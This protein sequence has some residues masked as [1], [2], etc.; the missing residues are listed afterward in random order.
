MTFEELYK[1]IESRRES[2]PDHSNTAK[3]LHAGKHQIS[4]KL[5]EEAA[6]S[7]MAAQF[8]SKNETAT[9]IAQLIYWAFVL[10]VASDIKLEELLEQL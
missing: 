7:M 5:I 2:N 3:Y 4:K 9:E 6:E 1:L 10:A 8:Q